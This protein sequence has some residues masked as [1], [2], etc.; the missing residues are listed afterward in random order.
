MEDIQNG[1][2]AV[3]AFAQPSGIATDGKY[4]YVCD[5]EGSSIRRVSI[6]AKGD[7]EVTT[8]VGA[9]DLPRGAALFE[10]GDIAGVGDKARLQHPLGVAYNDGSL[11]IADSYN[12]KIK[13]IDLKTR[14]S[15]TWLG[16]GTPGDRLEPAPQF[17]EPAGL[18]IAKGK[19]FV[20]DTNNHRILTVDLKTKATQELAIAGLKAPENRLANEDSFPK[21][22]PANKVTEHTV[23]AGQNVVFKI[24]LQLPEGYKINPLYPASF[25]VQAEGDQSVLPAEKIAGKQKASLKDDTATVT[26][27]MTG[28]TGKV[29]LQLALTY[30]YCRDGKGGLCKVSTT[31]WSLPLSVASDA[32]DAEVLLS[33]PKE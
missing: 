1:P 24:A 22:L 8:V 9:Y 33:V 27:P 30:G 16:D 5:S 32:K 10:F 7:G 26:V 21:D 15:T 23:R 11:Y 20:A 17:S 25:R 29:P 3:S 13:H 14:Q 6:T 4:L 31:R 2:L 12:H 18:A 19:L 28:E